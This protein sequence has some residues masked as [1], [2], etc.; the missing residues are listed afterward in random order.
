MQAFGAAVIDVQRLVL[1]DEV[2]A[3]PDHAAAVVAQRGVVQAGHAIGKPPMPAVAR[4][5]HPQIERLR[6]RMIHRDHAEIAAVDLER[7]ALLILRVAVVALV[8]RHRHLR[9][10]CTH[11]LPSGSWHERQLRRAQY[12]YDGT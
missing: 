10:P 2:L 9:D 12:S 11:V 5:G 4:R 7:N 1:H 3:L 6:D 8:G